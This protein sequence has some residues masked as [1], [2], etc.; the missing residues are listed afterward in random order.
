MPLFNKIQHLTGAQFKGKT[1]SSG[2]TVLVVGR[3]EDISPVTN[4]LVVQTKTGCLMYLAQFQMRCPDDVEIGKD[5]TLKGFTHVVQKIM[6]ISPD[7]FKALNAEEQQQV[8]LF[9]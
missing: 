4:D 1:F 5:E 7:K 6:K 9:F 3:I 8:S 2:E